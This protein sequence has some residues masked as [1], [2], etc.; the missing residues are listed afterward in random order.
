MEFLEQ[1]KNLVSGYFDLGKTFVSLVKL[2][3]RLAGLTLVPLLLNLVLLLVIGLSGWLCAMSLIHYLFYSL[4]GGFLSATALVLV[5]NLLV[6]ILLIKRLERN[7]KNM[8]FEKTRE[9]L[10]TT[11]RSDYEST[12]AIA[13]RDFQDAK[14]VVPSAE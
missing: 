13:T 7:I 2:E 3:A 1:F 8:S 6:F 9:F 10:S 11:E 12:S 14:Q 4:T 5:C